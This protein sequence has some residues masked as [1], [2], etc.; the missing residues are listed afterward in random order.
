MGFLLAWNYEFYAAIF[1]LL[2]YG[3][4][5]YGQLR[6]P[7]LLDRGPYILIGLTILVHG[8]LFIVYHFKIRPQS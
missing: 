1:F 3:L 5:L 2:W 6:Y 8:I 4:T 7:Q